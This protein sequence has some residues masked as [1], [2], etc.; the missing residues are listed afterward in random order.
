MSYIYYPGCSLE[1]SAIEYDASTRAVMHALD[2]ELAEIEG[3]SCCGATAAE[4]VSSLL[5]FVLPARN[6][7]LAEKMKQ[8]FSVMVPCSACYLNLKKVEMEKKQNPSMSASID[9]CLAE[10]ALKLEGKLKVRHLLDILANDIGAD[11]IKNKVTKK[12]SGL[13]IVP[14]YGCQCL[15]PYPVFDDP[16]EPRSMEPLIEACGAEVFPWDM[17]AQCCGASNMNTK[18]SAAGK[19]VQKILKSAKGADA[20]VTV[21]PMCQLNLEGFQEE[22][23]RKAGEDLSVSVIYLPQLLGMAMGISREELM[24]HKNLAVKELVLSY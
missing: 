15:R 24:L 16:E 18:K 17:G 12:L 13:K 1:A 21:C 4:P 2:I 19:L 23:S 20:I 10:E 11:Q 22:L 9:E 6:L 14:Y 3:W 7:A 5:S 8:N